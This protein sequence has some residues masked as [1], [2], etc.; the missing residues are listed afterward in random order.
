[1]KRIKEIEKSHGY[2]EKYEKLPIPEKL[3]NEELMKILGKLNKN[4]DE[5]SKIKENII[6]LYNALDKIAEAETSTYLV[7]PL[8]KALGWDNNLEVRLEQTKDKKRRDITLYKNDKIS[9]II[10]VKKARSSLFSAS[11]QIFG[12]CKA[13]ECKTAIITDGRRY[14]IF[15][16]DK[17]FTGSEVSSDDIKLNAYLDLMHT[18]RRRH[19]LYLSDQGIESALN[20][21]SRK[22]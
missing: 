21:L 2:N 16:T 13:E 17:G 15:K 22:K 8:L 14:A 11:Q 4:Y 19:P 10:E 5:F 7:L 18:D 6:A 20:E 12:Y 9:A 1:M 3:S